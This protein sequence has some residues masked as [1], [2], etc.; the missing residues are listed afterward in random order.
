MRLARRVSHVFP[1]LLPILLKTVGPLKHLLWRLRTRPTFTVDE[2]T[3]DM[4]PQ[5]LEGYTNKL[6]YKPGETVSFHL[7]A[8]Q[9][10]NQLLVQRYVAHG[11]WEDLAIHSFDE[12]PQEETI[13]EAQ[14]GCH[15]AVGWHY[16]LAPESPAGYYRALLSSRALEQTSEIHFL[17]GSP[18]SGSK[19]AVLAPM[20]TWL[21]YNAYGGQSLYRN[22]IFD[23]YVPFASAL[24]PNT[25]LSYQCT[26]SYQHNL[27]IEANI[28][29]WFSR[30]HQADLYPDFYLE[31]HPELFQE[32]EVLVL[33]YH[34]EYFSDKMY[35]ALRE[36]VFQKQKSLLAL[37]GNQVYWQVR[38]HQNFTQLECR[39]NGSFFQN[40]AK[41]GCLWRH[42]PHPEAQLLGAH[43]S[44]PGIGTF[45][46]YKVLA[47]FHWLFE[48]TE[49]KEGDLFGEHGLD[50]LPICGDETD[51]TTWSSPAQ[52]VVIAKGL[53]KTEATVPHTYV[54][55]DPTWNGS[56]G[57]EI[58]LTELSNKH[59]VLNTGSI[60]S[61]SGLGT[62]RVFTQLIQNFMQRYCRTSS[63]DTTSAGIAA[64]PVS[65][66]APGAPGK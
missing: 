8:L 9:P 3:P 18:V 13:D 16:A 40:E 37:G 55:G 42:T 52:T 20:T 2:V 5:P 66:P 57:G 4:V 36:L 12:L 6:Y 30:H 11:K 27:Q 53:N 51:K 7:K 10:Q 54:A 46:P 49:T 22:A 47:P 63:G 45:A 15:W 41:R 23:G 62:D 14:S 28:F 19:V 44:E 61:G 39:K 38:C 33:A 59:A 65:A 60:Q 34:A 32:Y 35:Q 56:G 64:A 29:Q 43:F 50:G 48:G 17:V 58:T 21:A 31:A 1:A 24:R 25:A 26:T